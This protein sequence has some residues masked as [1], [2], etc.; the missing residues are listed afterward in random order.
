MINSIIFSSDG[1]A[2]TMTKSGSSNS[3]KQQGTINH[4]KVSKNNSI[5]V[6]PANWSLIT[7]Q[8]MITN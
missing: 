8:I 6:H 7:V 5:Y 3:G 2:T 4:T 1:S